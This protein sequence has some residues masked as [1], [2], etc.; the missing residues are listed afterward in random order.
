MSERYQL[1]FYVRDSWHQVYFPALQRTSLNCRPN[2]KTSSMEQEEVVILNG[3]PK[4]L[5]EGNPEI[6]R[7][8]ISLNAILKSLVL[9]YTDESNGNSYFTKEGCGAML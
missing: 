4:A 9:G 2:F 1:R 6:S 8:S 3:M 5:F 7:T